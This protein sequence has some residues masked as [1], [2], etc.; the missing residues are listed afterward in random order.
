MY[1]SFA[2]KRLILNLKRKTFSDNILSILSQFEKRP[3]ILNVASALKSSDIACIYRSTLKK[4][5]RDAKIFE[6]I[7]CAEFFK[8]KNALWKHIIQAH[9]DTKVFTYSFRFNNFAGYLSLTPLFSNLVV[10]TTNTVN[11]MFNSIKMA[12]ATNQSQQRV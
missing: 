5:H 11:L 3:N 1:V 9:K 7:L 8:E 4:A 2:L 6:C 12:T 10:S